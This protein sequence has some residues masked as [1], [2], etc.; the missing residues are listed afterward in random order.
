MV[1]IIIVLYSK[2]IIQI[3][4]MLRMSILLLPMVNYDIRFWDRRSL[5]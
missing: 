4:Y 1:I 2:E 3:L 5:L